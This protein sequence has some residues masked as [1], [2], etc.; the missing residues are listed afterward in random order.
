MPYDVSPQH[1]VDGES[2]VH[3][4]SATYPNA[5]EE[6][7]VRLA[8]QRILAAHLRQSDSSKFWDKIDIDLVGASL[9]SFEF[10]NCCAASMHCRDAVFTDGASFYRAVFEG[11]A[12]FGGAYFSSERDDSANF[13]EAVFRGSSS[14]MDTSFA[15]PTSFRGAHFSEEAVFHKSKFESIVNFSATCFG[16][17]ATFSGVAS[18]CLRASTGSASPWTGSGAPGR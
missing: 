3:I 10:R 15:G 12:D 17:R 14:F 1:T 5:R 18:Q 4:L 16:K 9:V 8:A 2:E 7:Q 11:R 6:L 13:I